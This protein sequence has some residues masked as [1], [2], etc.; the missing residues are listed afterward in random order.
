MANLK[1]LSKFYQHNMKYVTR[2]DYS[3]HSKLSLF[4]THKYESTI[5]SDKDDMYVSKRFKDNCLD[6]LLDNMTKYV[7][8]E[9]KI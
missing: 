2:I 5:I 1:K 9:I 6:S 4:T 8:D 3:F 7:N